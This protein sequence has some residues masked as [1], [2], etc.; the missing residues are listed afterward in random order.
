MKLIYRFCS[1]FLTALLL[2][3]LSRAAHAEPVP[4]RYQR[5]SVRGFLELR[6][7]DGRV[8]ASGDFTQIAHGDRIISETVFHFHD[9]SVDDETTVYTQRRILQLL[10]DHRIQKGPS[11]PH[12]MD[13]LIDTAS[14]QVT[15]RSVGKDGKTEVKIDHLDL[16]PD[17][18]NGIISAV[19]ENM[20]TSDPPKTVSLLL[21]TPKPLLARLIITPQGDDKA[22][23][24]G[25]PR[26]A[27]H[28]EIRSIW[29]G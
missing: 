8:V 27:N 4:V 2:C 20:R 13:V 6:S 18:A 23:V 3:C 14:G 7:E 25:M 24:A 9:G 19:A 1:S 29:A 21:A 11:F 10:T 5:G 28:Y 22:S 26:K 15:V 16:P 12:P 17:L